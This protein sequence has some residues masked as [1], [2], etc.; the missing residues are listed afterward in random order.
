MVAEGVPG[1]GHCLLRDGYV[2]VR[3]D[4]RPVRRHRR[5]DRAAD[6]GWAQRAAAAGD[7]RRLLC[8]VSVLGKK[9]DGLTNLFCWGAC[10]ADAWLERIRDLY[11]AVDALM[12]A[13][14]EAAMPRRKAAAR[15]DEAYAAWNKAISVI[16]DAQKKQLAP[17]CSSP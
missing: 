11:A 13:W 12:A 4:A 14:D 16:D 8:R 1:P 3:H 2:P 7:P 6:G 5:E 10:E 9:A 15:L 17:A